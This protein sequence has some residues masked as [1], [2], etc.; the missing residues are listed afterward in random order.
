MFL[1]LSACSLGEKPKASLLPKS[2]G[3]VTMD[4]ES[5]YA[6]TDFTGEEKLIVLKSS[7]SPFSTYYYFK[8]NTVR[9]VYDDLET[10]LE[11]DSLP[12]TNLAWLLYR[13]IEGA[14]KEG[15][16][17]EKA[18][19]KMLFSFKI[20]NVTCSGECSENGKLLSL[21]VPQYKVYYKTK[22]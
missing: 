18:D 22:F 3:T 8:G 12:D 16:S 11:T 20:N 17:W 13:A 19:D 5:F 1:F 2:R 14:A 21:E 10:E 15:T 4:E 7:Q 6:E 9:L